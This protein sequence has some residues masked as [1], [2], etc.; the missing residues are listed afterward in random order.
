VSG[1]VPN[2]NGKEPTVGLQPSQPRTFETRENLTSVGHEK[3]EV[4]GPPSDLWPASPA[5]GLS[6]PGDDADAVRNGR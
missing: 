5:L 3:Q 6:Q 2:A 4:H 1:V